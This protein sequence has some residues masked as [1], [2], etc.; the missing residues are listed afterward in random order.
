MLLSLEKLAQSCMDGFLL[1]DIG[2]LVVARVARSFH[3][4][5]YI[6]LLCNRASLPLLGSVQESDSPLIMEEEDLIGRPRDAPANVLLMQ[7]RCLVL[8][9]APGEFFV[10]TICVLQSKGKGEAIQAH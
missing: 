5:F 8:F 10:A 6:L 4:S 2:S 9:F 1:L 3:Y 7:T